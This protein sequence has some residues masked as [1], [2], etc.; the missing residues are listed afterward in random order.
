MRR[1]SQCFLRWPFGSER[2]RSRA[3]GASHLGV[4]AAKTGAHLDYVPLIIG[5]VVEACFEWCASSL[6]R[7]A[8]LALRLSRG[9]TDSPPRRLIPVACE[10]VGLVLHQRSSLLLL[11][12]HQPK[13]PSSFG[14]R[15][16]DHSPLQS[17]SA[18]N[19]NII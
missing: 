4:L 11:L 3:R 10:P 1:H 15:R 9:L 14:R 12:G 2:R 16:T 13:R 5:L 8:A 6:G 18:N 7:P 17:R 19:H